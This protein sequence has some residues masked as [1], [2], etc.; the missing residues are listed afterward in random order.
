MPCPEQVSW[1]P[2][3]WGKQARELHCCVAFLSPSG[4]EVGLT[5][6]SSPS[7]KPWPL[8]GCQ[9]LSCTLEVVEPTSQQSWQSTPFLSHWR[10]SPS[11]SARQLT[12]LTHFVTP[13]FL[14]LELLQYLCARTSSCQAKSPSAHREGGCLYSQGRPQ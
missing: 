13:S 12:T 3:L 14:L 10:H 6:P 11:V 4:S 5:N 2:P 9:T 8:R 7:N 1:L